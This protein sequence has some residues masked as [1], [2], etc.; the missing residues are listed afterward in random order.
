MHCTCNLVSSEVS[1][2]CYIMVS[3]GSLPD[4]RQE[5]KLVDVVKVLNDILHTATLPYFLRP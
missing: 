4:L 1:V 5:R 2:Q 3:G